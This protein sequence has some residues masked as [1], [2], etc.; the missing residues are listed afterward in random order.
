MDYL[1]NA[2]VTDSNFRFLSLQVLSLL[3]FFIQTG[4][5]HWKWLYQLEFSLLPRIKKIFAQHIT[6]GPMIT[7]ASFSR[8]RGKPLKLLSPTKQSIFIVVPRRLVLFILTTVKRLTIF[9][10]LTSSEHFCLYW[11][12][13]RS[14]SLL[15]LSCD[16]WRTGHW[17]FR[18]FTFGVQMFK[19]IEL[20]RFKREYWISLN[21][22]ISQILMP[23]MLVT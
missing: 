15:K 11:L 19:V 1:R 16:E 8:E 17:D 7:S 9:G 6:V 13:C 18:F 22:F 3:S 4:I 21:D 20:K 2:R 14:L 12:P 10:L 23:I 5:E